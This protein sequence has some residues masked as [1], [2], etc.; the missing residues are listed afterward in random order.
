MG[1]IPAA[2]GGKLQR[3]TWFRRHHWLF[4]TALPS[5]GQPCLVLLSES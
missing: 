2:A 3:E 1:R 5:S 4:T